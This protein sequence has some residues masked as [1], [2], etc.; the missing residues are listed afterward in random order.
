MHTLRGYPI[1]A[2]STLC[3]LICKVFSDHACAFLEIAS[4][5]PKESY[6][7]E[8]TWEARNGT[9]VKTAGAVTVADPCDLEY[10]H[11]KPARV[12]ASS[13]CASVN[14]TLTNFVWVQF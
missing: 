13:S 7:Q 1:Q 5:I 10:I 2:P 4:K 6:Q 12:Q 11:V 9:G 14:I 3:Y 8:K